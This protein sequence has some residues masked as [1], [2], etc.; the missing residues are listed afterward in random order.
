ML[1]LTLSPHA[2]AGPLWLV[3]IDPNT[4]ETLFLAE[5]L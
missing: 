1:T 2:P 3:W 5:I 4:G